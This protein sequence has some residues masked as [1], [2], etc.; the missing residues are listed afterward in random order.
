MGRY[1]SGTLEPVN[2]ADGSVP[3]L[4]FRKV[5]LSFPALLPCVDCVHLIAYLRCFPTGTLLVY[6]GG[7]VA[8]CPHFVRGGGDCQV[9]ADAYSAL[10]VWW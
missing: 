9:P 1:V 2:G 10:G 5:C 7:T 6:I 4:S 8:S 3:V